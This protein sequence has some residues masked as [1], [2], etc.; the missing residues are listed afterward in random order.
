MKLQIANRISDKTLTLDLVEFDGVVTLTAETDDSQYRV[1]SFKINDDN[2][3]EFQ[4]VP[5]IGHDNFR[6]DD[7]GRLIEETIEDDEDVADQDIYAYD[8]YPDDD[9]VADPLDE[10]E[11]ALGNFV[12]DED[13]EEDEEEYV[14]AARGC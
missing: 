2:E 8:D 11:A 9:S 13:D 6:T 1:L 7:Y 12:I 5:G 10:F 14:D 3:L 4:R